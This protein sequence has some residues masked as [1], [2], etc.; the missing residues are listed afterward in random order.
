MRTGHWLLLL[1]SVGAE[2][3]FVLVLQ[4]G[5][6]DM[7]VVRE[8][9]GDEASAFHICIYALKCPRIN[10]KGHYSHHSLRMF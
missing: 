6:T 5:L 4:E 1:S 3:A 2:I 10:L 8:D 7:A 9:R